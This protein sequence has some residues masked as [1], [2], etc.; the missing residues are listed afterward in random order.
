MRPRHWLLLAA[1]LI[2]V[3]LWP[4][5]AKVTLGLMADGA[6]AI[7]TQIPGLLL[8]IGGGGWFIHRASTPGNRS[9]Y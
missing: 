5:L 7:L 1:L 6:T 3:G 4:P 2:A 9:S 8:L